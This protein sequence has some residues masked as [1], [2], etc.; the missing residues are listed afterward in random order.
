ME[1]YEFRDGWDKIRVRFTKTG[2]VYIDMPL[3]YGRR[4][5][6][7]RDSIVR[8]QRSWRFSSTQDDCIDYYF[9]MWLDDNGTLS[10]TND[11]MYR[12]EYASGKFDPNYPNAGV[13]NDTAIKL[14]NVTKRIE[15]YQKRNLPTREIFE[16][17]QLYLKTALKMLGYDSV[18]SVGEKLDDSRGYFGLTK[19]VDALENYVDLSRVVYSLGKAGDYDLFQ[20]RIGEDATRE[21]VLEFAKP[22]KYQIDELV[23]YMKEREDGLKEKRL[24]YPEYKKQ[25]SIKA[26]E[27]T[28]DEYEEKVKSVA[29][30]LLELNADLLSEEQRTKFGIKQVMFV[31]AI[32][33]KD[34]IS[35]LIDTTE[36]NNVCGIEDE[37][38][39]EEAEE[40]V[41]R[42]NV[43]N[44]SDNP[45]K[46]IFSRE[47]IV[48]LLSSELGE[49]EE[50]KQSVTLQ[51]TIHKKYYSKKPKEAKKLEKV[52]EDEYVH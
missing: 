34:K 18:D 45:A 20:S 25:M 50:R 9:H 2:G 47:D 41:R 3:R 29:M 51:Q 6:I 40:L 15:D 36:F 10:W 23:K 1:V 28:W 37:F 17:R 13:L 26:G 49:L 12:R 31:E 42:I 24:I 48:R 33:S 7:L 43:L 22:V 19:V 52:L 27:Y 30:L 46:D 5:A 32:E 8:E 4:G 11:M 38:V 44:S 14:Y 35:K 39:Y 21:N 16:L